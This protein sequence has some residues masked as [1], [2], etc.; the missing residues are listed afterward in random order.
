MDRGRTFLLIHICTT[1]HFI[2]NFRLHA[3]RHIDLQKKRSEAK[4]T[5]RA[6]D[7]E[8]K[9]KR[10]FDRSFFSFSRRR[11]AREQCAERGK[12]HLIQFPIRRTCDVGMRDALTSAC[13]DGRPRLRSSL[14]S[15]HI[16]CTTRFFQVT[17]TRLI[18][19]KSQPRT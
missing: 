18:Q 6:S 13:E 3:E 16:L 8:A 7:S 5:C 17:C 15:F 1:L 12:R 19:L 2:R 9:M 4:S 10:A 11:R 14:I